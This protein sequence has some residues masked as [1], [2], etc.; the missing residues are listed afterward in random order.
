MTKGYTIANCYGIYITG[1][2]TEEPE[3]LVLKLEPGATVRV[4][5]TGTLEIWSNAPVRIVMKDVEIIPDAT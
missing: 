2:G 4:A 5:P 3:R 1:A